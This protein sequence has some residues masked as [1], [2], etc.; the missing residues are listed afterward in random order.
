MP[1]KI[2]WT[3]E[4][5]NPLRAR[6]RESGRA[7]HFCVHHS[8]G[9]KFCYAEILQKRFG[10]PVRYAAQDA[11]KVEL[12]LDE[13]V[14]TAPL[15]WRRP[16]TV[17]VCSMTDLFYEGYGDDLI[18]KVFAV[19]AIA[20]QHRFQVL[21][22]RADRMR[23][24]FEAE[25]WDRI[26]GEAGV[27]WDWAK[28]PQLGPPPIPNVWLGVSVEDQQRAVER[29]PHLLDTPAAVRFLSVEPLLGP[30]DLRRWMTLFPHGPCGPMASA[31]LDWVIVGGESGPNAR[32]MYPGWAR[33]IR[34]QC[35]TAGVPFF[36]KQWGEWDWLEHQTYGD[37]EVIAN[38][39][40]VRYEHH[41]YGPTAIK[42]GKKRAGR[43]L[44]GRT[45]D[46]MPGATA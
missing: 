3:D 1:T 32:P 39:L 9:C 8:P 25:P 40:R 7:G 29:I 36:F 22:K 30:I 18:D 4:T 2:E 33:S 17:F 19:M 10:N 16:R 38:S 37:A 27:L 20:Q 23:A 24:Y 13:K 44:D 28:I 41:S 15:R 21:T 35:Q 46:E 12:F 5:W 14:L 6:N 43:E 45:W 11:D 31:T 26:N 42:V 34:D